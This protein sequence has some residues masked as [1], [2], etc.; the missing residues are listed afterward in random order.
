[1]ERLL[2]FYVDESGNTGANIF[3]ASQ[4]RLYY[5]VLFSKID[6]DSEAES[7]LVRLRKQLGVQ[8]IHASELGN[9]RI[10]SIVKDISI[11]QRNY[12]IV[13]DIYTV[14]KEDHAII[15]FFDQVF[16]QGNNPA[17]TWTGYWTPLRYI[18]LL[19][20]ASLFDQEMARKAWDARIEQKYQRAETLLS[21]IC[22]EIRGRVNRLP[23]AR[24]RQLIA[25]ALQWAEYH[26]KEIRYNVSSHKDLLSITPNIIGFQ[27]VMQGIA[28]RIAMNGLQASKIVVDQQSQFNKSQRTL[29]DY[30]SGMRNFKCAI[31]P[32][33]PE[34]D[35][36]TMPEVPIT[37]SSGNN[38]AGL[39][40]VD[41]YLWVFK[42]FIENGNLAPEMR[43]IIDR[44]LQQGYTDEVSLKGIEGRW[45]RWFSELSR[46]YPSLTEEQLVSAKEMLAF[47]EE[48]RLRAMRG[49]S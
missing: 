42:R 3:D 33:M 24:S 4:P 45:T 26:P 22:R 36:S 14:V 2:F 20:I 12:D 48:R 49:E 18:L 13:F 10:A 16:D 31:G 6:L 29:A 5:G 35:F 9:R 25:D 17:I 15:S 38:S 39:E 34:I 1:M 40:L 37:F 47:D 41:L 7:Y 46:R 44:Q 23:D 28:N 19:K 30:Y 11:V 21:E 27:I 8:R 43:L 32:G